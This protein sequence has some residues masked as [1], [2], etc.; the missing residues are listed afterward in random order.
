MKALIL[1]LIVSNA[2]SLLSVNGIVA[3]SEID[4][5]IDIDTEAIIIEAAR[6]EI[7]GM[8]YIEFYYLVNGE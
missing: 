4:T 8:L 2:L 7:D 3:A 6:A 1:L 5:V